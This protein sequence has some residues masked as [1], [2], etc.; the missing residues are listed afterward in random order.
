VTLS[1]FESINALKKLRRQPNIHIKLDTG[2]H[3]Q[4]FLPHQIHRVIRELERAGIIKE[5]EGIYTHFASA[6]DR[7]Y[8]FYTKQQIEKFDRACLYFQAHGFMPFL[9]HA[10]ATGG[11]ILHPEARYDM[12]RIGIGLYGLW[13]S[14]E[15]MLQH[16]LPDANGNPPQPI[17][18]T[19]ILA[20]KAIVSEVKRIPSGSFVGY[21]LT[22]RV[23]RPTTIAV[24][25]VGYWH[26]VDR[27]LSSV[28]RVLVRGRRAKILGR[29]SMDMMV[30]DVTD[31]PRVK[32]GETAVLIG[33]QGREEI[34]AYEWA[35]KLG[36][37]NYEIITRLN[38]LIK[39]VY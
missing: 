4:G 3:R 1:T 25:P 39:R 10:A 19:P 7:T 21:D 31:I 8:P 32:P 33:K 20:W 36:T 38:P 23:V 30:V 2:M 17:T 5:V 27:R 13:P 14:K 15:L 11:T 26:G 29:V 18:L 34:T 12:V 9:Q 35:E 16:A 37:T 22:E 24:I 28:G 6:K